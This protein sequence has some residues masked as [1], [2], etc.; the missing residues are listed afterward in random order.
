MFPWFSNTAD[1]IFDFLKEENLLIKQKQLLKNGLIQILS[2]DLS[3]IVLFNHS[4]HSK[5]KIL[6]DNIKAHLFPNIM[7]AIGS[8]N[9]SEN[10]AALLTLQ[11][12]LTSSTNLNSITLLFKETLNPLVQSCT[13]L[14]ICINNNFSNLAQKIIEIQNKSNED[15]TIFP[16]VKELNA[17]IIIILNKYGIFYINI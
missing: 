3:L 1:V 7:I 15:P 6:D 17:E 16:N 10:L 8:L 12:I 13:K 4:K 2:K 14:L 9:Y 11:A 5:I